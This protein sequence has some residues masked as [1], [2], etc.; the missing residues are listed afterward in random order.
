MNRIGVRRAKGSG[1]PRDQESEGGQESQGAMED[2]EDGGLSLFLYQIIDFAHISHSHLHLYSLYYAA[3]L[4][5]EY[6]ICILSRV[7]ESQMVMENRLRVFKFG[8]VTR[9]IWLACPNPNH[10]PSKRASVTFARFFVEYM[11]HSR[12]PDKLSSDW[13]RPIGRPI[14]LMGRGV[15]GSEHKHNIF[16][17]G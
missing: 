14:E 16:D 9:T 7:C 12:P 1:E 4:N 3:R 10:L 13:D 15:N 2:K 5:R 11:G 8:G 17:M 6:S